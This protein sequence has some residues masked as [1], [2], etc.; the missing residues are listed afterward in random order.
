MEFP[1]CPDILVESQAKR[2]TLTFDSSKACEQ[3]GKL[4]RNGK[5]VI[6]YPLSASTSS[7][8][9]LTYVGYS[10]QNDSIQGTREFNLTALDQV[11][12]TFTNVKISSNLQVNSTISGTLNHTLTKFRNKLTGFSSMGTISG[13]NPAGRLFLTELKSPRQSLISC[14]SQNE[15]LPISGKEI[16]T[17]NRG[18]NQTVTHSLSY[19][20][21]GSCTTTATV[22][23]SDG[24]NLQVTL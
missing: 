15:V 8:W 16:W 17:V 6:Q 13:V 14:Y 19:E 5:L 2:I 3:S 24:R 4:K 23:L 10:L 18:K 9:S 11:M 20:S 22:R 1:G 21:S 12:E 7:K